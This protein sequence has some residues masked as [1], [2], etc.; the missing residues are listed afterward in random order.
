[1]VNISEVVKNMTPD[2][3]GE[4]NSAVIILN[5]GDCCRCAIV[6]IDAMHIGAQAVTLAVTMKDI[7]DRDFSAALKLGEAFKAASGK[8]AISREGEKV[9]CYKNDDPSKFSADFDALE[10]EVREKREP[11]KADNKRDLM[12]AFASAIVDA[13]FNDKGGASDA[14]DD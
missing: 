9:N 6:G 2:K 10:K 7:L 14:H 12:E 13:M 4:A 5:D 3:S 11:K 8:D 1:M